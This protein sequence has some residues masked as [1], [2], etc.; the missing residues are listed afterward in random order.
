MSNAQQSV[1]EQPV[2]ADP[3]AQTVIEIG[4]QEET[5]QGVGLPQVDE[6]SVQ[7]AISEETKMKEESVPVQQAQVEQPEE[8]AAQPT[9]RA[10]LYRHPTHQIVGGVCGGLAEYLNLDPV[11]VRLLWIV[12]TIPTAGAGILAYIVLWLLLPV[13]TAH[14]GQREPAA[15]NINESSLRRAGSVLVIFGGLWF[16]AN[17]GILPWIWNAFWSVASIVFWPALLVGAGMLLL[18]NQKEWRV[19]FQDWR[20][21][22]RVSMPKMSSNLHVD[23]STIKSGLSNARQRIPLKRSR[24]DRLWL[25]VSGGMAESLRLDANLIRLFWILFS[26]GTM[27]FGV[28]LYAVLGALLPVRESSMSALNYD[29]DIDAEPQQVQIIDAGAK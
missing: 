10:P 3:S 2:Q 13:G 17:V 15:I 11:L 29:G 16:L 22:A 26:L 1:Q 14:G 19:S 27:G 25:G 4:Q 6:G 23:R 18:K 9:V 21:R 24:T 7:E 20:N 12:M 28:L 5:P 8:N